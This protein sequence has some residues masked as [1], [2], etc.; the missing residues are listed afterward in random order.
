MT[1]LN[2]NIANGSLTY[3][4][5]TISAMIIVQFHFNVTNLAMSLIFRH[6][7]MSGELYT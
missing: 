4:A 7:M 2:F 6:A 3:D 1:E 5:G